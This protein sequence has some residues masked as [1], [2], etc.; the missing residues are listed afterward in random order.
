MG[1]TIRSVRM[2]AVGGG[3]REG[4]SADDKSLWR[5]DRAERLR[6]AQRDEKRIQRAEN[7]T[8]RLEGDGW[9]LGSTVRT[10]TA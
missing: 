9:R 6:L 5:A 7:H 2:P 4:T 8:S 1:K 3:V 10:V